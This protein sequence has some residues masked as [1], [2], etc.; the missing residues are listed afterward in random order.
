MV[1]GP[2]CRRHL[3]IKKSSKLPSLKR[4]TICSNFAPEKLAMFFF[5]PKKRKDSIDHRLQP[6]EFSEWGKTKWSREGF[7]EVIQL[8]FQRFWVFW[9]R[10]KRLM[11]DTTSLC[12]LRIWDWKEQSPPCWVYWWCQIERKNK[13]CWGSK[14]DLRPNKYIVQWCSPRQHGVENVPI[15]SDI[16]IYIIYD[17]IYVSPK[18]K[19]KK[20]TYNYIKCDL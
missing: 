14:H 19:S 20:H 8:I 17:R 12:Q 10:D 6:L 13:E 9:L 15:S 4:S 16:N 3:T 1:G 11:A 5:H 2:P 7:S 18:Y